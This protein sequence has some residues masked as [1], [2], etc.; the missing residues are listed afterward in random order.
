MKLRFEIET[1]VVGMRA[2]QRSTVKVHRTWCMFKME[3]IL[4]R[5][6][7]YSDWAAKKPP[8]GSIWLN[9]FILLVTRVHKLCLPKKILN[10][11]NQQSQKSLVRFIDQSR[12]LRSKQQ[13]AC[14]FSNNPIE[15]FAAMLHRKLAIRW[16]LS[17]KPNCKQNKTHTHTH[18]HTHTKPPLATPLRN[19]SFYS[20]CSAKVSTRW[21]PPVRRGM[22]EEV[23]VT[24]STV[25]PGTCGPAIMRAL[26]V[27]PELLSEPRRVIEPHVLVERVR[28]QCAIW[29]R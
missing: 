1:V 13:Q 20:L 19:V 28:R 14:F 23:R 9:W 18:T 24:L 4:Y 21:A 3:R 6:E 12:D 15:S 8:E 7:L 17:P 5:D 29:I 10:Q 25:K 27:V 26:S 22:A 16:F 11:H 2:V